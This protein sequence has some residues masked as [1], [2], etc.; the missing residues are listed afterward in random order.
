MPP[1]RET[2]EGMAANPAGASTAVAPGSEV[3]TS[4]E[5]TSG[6]TRVPAICSVTGTSKRW[7]PL[8]VTF[9]WAV[10]V[11]PGREG[12]DSTTSGMV[13]D[14]PWKTVLP[15]VNHGWSLTPWATAARFSCAVTVTACSR[16]SPGLP[17]RT[18]ACSFRSTF[19][20]L[21][22]PSTSKNCCTAATPEAIGPWTG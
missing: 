3:G 8:A 2:A 13:A 21:T 6:P 7:L 20:A 22:R 14:F 15:T 16:R 1:D 10:S 19:G 11:S 4:D 12:T 5:S 9:R 18:T 17:C